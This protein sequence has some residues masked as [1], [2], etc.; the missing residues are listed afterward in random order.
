MYLEVPELAA[1]QIYMKEQPVGQGALE[2]LTWVAL[3]CSPVTRL[4]L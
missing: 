2:A 4:L 1:V 3:E